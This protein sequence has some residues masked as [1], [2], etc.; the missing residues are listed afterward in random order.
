MNTPNVINVFNKDFLID[1]VELYNNM[2][3]NI[4]LYNQF[5]FTL[6]WMEKKRFEEKRTKKDGIPRINI[7]IN[8]KSKFSYT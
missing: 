2:I 5:K 4:I 1:I 8:W 3:E 7:S 6:N